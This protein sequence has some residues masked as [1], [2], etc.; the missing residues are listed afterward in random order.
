[1]TDTSADVEARYRE[2]LLALPPAARL[3]M[4]SRMFSTARA[5]AVAGL[6]LET[7]SSNSIRERLFRRLYGRDFSQ[8]EADRIAAHLRAA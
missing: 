7:E 4:A 5:L 8:Q 1:M 6:K 3:E 2:R